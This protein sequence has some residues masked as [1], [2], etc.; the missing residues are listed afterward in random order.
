MTH[1]T[2][3]KTY[4]KKSNMT[5][6]T[7]V[8]I[9]LTL[10]LLVTYLP[11][12]FMYKRLYKK[13][14]IKPTGIL[15]LKVI[16]AYFII[17]LIVGSILGGLISFSADF[18]EQILGEKLVYD[19]VLPILPFIAFVLLSIPCPWLLSAKCNI[20]SHLTVPSEILTNIISCILF[21]MLGLPLL[22]WLNGFF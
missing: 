15:G 22:L 17:A 18:F 9:P 20:S 12:Y 2:H 6:K 7:T 10:F 16:S 19:I 5:E 8:F 11:R 3:K 1:T 14:E 21:V 13:L 4:T